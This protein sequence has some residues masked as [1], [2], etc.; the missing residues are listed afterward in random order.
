MP[1]DVETVVQVADEHVE[2]CRRLLPPPSTWPAGA[3]LLTAV[4]LSSTLPAG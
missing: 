2:A 1:V 3:S 4:R